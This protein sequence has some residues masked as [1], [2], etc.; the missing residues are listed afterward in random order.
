ML[1][2]KNIIDNI[3]KINCILYALDKYETFNASLNIIVL[4]K[5]IINILDKYNIARLNNTMI[6]SNRF[7]S[8]F[9]LRIIAI[10]KHNNEM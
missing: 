10:I 8:F 1:L 4:V 2:I 3:E 7:F 5:V 9:K 6:L